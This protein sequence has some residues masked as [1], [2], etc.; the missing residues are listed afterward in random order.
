MNA[1]REGGFIV[2]QRQIQSS[3]LWLSLRAEQR[4]VFIQMLLMA[5]WAPSRARWKGEWYEVKRGELSH[6]M[7]TIAKEARVSVAVVRSTID[8]MMADD[9]SVGGNG[10][11][12][13]QRYPVEHT[14]PSTGPRVLTIVNYNK[15]Q[16][17]PVE[18]RTVAD[19]GDAQEVAQTSHSP[20]TDL[21]Q[22]EQEQQEQQEKKLQLPAPRPSVSPPSPV[23]LTIPCVGTGPTEVGITQAQIERWATLFPGVDVIGQVRAAVAWAEANPTKRK[24]ASGIPRYITGWLTRQQNNGGTVQ[25]K[26]TT[27]N[28]KAMAPVGQDWSA[29]PW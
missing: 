19:T 12:L 22:R 7:A 3:A 26:P 2:V 17:V 16:D 29:K 27:P 23:V 21:A 24:T 4:A 18:A 13:A 11:F 8:A 28:P 10:P 15:H 1:D 5:N 14:G 9:R 25:G 6:T 20:H